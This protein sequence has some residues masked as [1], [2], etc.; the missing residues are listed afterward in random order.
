MFPL[1]DGQ[2]QTMGNDEN[3]NPYLV[4]PDPWK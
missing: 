3:G 1:P 2:I 4:Q